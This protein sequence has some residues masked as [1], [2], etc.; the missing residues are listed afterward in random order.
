MT[1]IKVNKIEA[2]RRQIDTAIRL[3]FGN[4]DPVAIHTLTMAGFRILRDL[5]NKRN[6]NMNKIAQLFIKPGMEGKFWGTLQSF[7]N[8]LKHAD[9]DPD[10]I[11]DNIQEEVNDAILFL[12]T[13]Y[14]LYRFE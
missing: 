12:A 7:A 3:L 6:S 5:S 2:A 10:S 13:L 11:I 9:E 14:Y 1:T 4:E 8:F